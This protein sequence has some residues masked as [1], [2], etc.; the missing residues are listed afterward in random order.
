M[1][2]DVHV[3]DPHCCGECAAK[4]DEMVADGTVVA[5]APPDA[6]S[7]RIAALIEK[8]R[9]YK[10]VAGVSERYIAARRQSADELEAA[11]RTARE[12][13]GEDRSR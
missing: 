12:G 4:Y 11:L 7:A 6:A 3:P 2:T 1:A 8:W 5:A 9:S 10:P 13:T